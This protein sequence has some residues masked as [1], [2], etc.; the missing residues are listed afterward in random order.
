ML[1]DFLK[2]LNWV[3]ILMALVF[4][5]IIFIGIKTGFMIEFFKFW[6]VLFSTVISLHY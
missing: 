6:G 2:S 4:A 1:M 3:D 5:R